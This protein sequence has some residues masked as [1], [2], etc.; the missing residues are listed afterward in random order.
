MTE[1]VT[2]MR[3]SEEDLEQFRL[4]AKENGMNQQQAFKSLVSLVELEK[5]R[6]TS[7][8]R[9]KEIDVF[10]DTVNKLIGFYTNSLEINKTTEE[11]I[12][13]ELKKEL[14]AKDST[15]ANLQDLLRA[16]KEDNDNLKNNYE[17]LESN[18]KYLQ[19]KIE[20][21]TKTDI[22][23]SRIINTL[24]NSNDLLQEQFKNIMKDCNKLQAEN[25]EE[26]GIFDG[27]EFDKFLS[28]YKTTEIGLT[29]ET[30][31]SSEY[32]LLDNL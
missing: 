5:A 14:A 19:Q 24:T 29:D 18:N 16:T 12:R 15:I 21:L 13:E 30:S 8:E 17:K 25:E 26:D 6:T 31:S 23:N 9:A 7:P 10:R 3:L 20:E 11:T 4:F 27:E 2:S 32:G 22:N 1:K 28:T